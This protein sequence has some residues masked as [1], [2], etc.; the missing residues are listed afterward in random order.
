MEDIAKVTQQPPR[1]GV[2]SGSTG[3]SVQ[4]VKQQD[5]IKETKKELETQANKI[6]SPKDVQ[7]LVKQ[8]NKTIEP[9]ST[10]LSFG[11]DNNDI[12]YVLVKD[13]S[14]NQIISRFPAEQ[15]ANFLP[16]MKEVTGI[17]FDSKG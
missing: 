15:A 11:V 7:N 12:F 3:N 17:L 14:S 1:Q 10:S 6:K 2:V 13:L 16:K 9:L 4:Q 5:V 8:L